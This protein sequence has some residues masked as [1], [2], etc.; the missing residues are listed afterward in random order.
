MGKNLTASTCRL[1]KQQKQRKQRGK[2]ELQHASDPQQ[3][4]EGESHGDD[5]V[6][7]PSTSTQDTSEWDFDE[8]AERMD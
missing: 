6:L 3:H 5:P 1:R 4:S 2:A 8:W 7:S